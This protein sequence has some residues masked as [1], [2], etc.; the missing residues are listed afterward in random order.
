MDTPQFRWRGI[1][2]GDPDRLFVGL[3]GARSRW[4]WHQAV[5]W[6]PRFNRGRGVGSQQ[7][8]GKRPI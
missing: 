5:A 6:V 1:A 3:W 7:E 8:S 4:V 2:D